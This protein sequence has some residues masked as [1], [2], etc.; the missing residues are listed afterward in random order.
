M[1]SFEGNLFTQ[2]HDICSQETRD[3]TLSYAENPESL[4]HMGYIILII[5]SYKYISPFLN[6]DAMQIKDKIFLTKFNRVNYISQIFE[7]CL[8]KK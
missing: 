4:S 5:A 6:N 3:S 1:P 8:E 2:R 7:F